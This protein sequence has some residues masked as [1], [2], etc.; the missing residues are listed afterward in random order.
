MSR[1]G[2]RGS[3]T[4][5]IRYEMFAINPPHSLDLQGCKGCGGGTKADG[6]KQVCSKTV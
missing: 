4:G 6:W 5:A 2:T 1:T 3:E